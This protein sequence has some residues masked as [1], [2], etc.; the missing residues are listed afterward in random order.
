MI[1]ACVRTGTKYPFEYVVKLRNMVER[2]AGDLA[3]RF[4]CLT[5]QLE[6]CFGIEFI[7]ISSEGLPGWW[8][9]MTLLKWHWRRMQRVVY[10]DLDT[11]IVGDLAPLCRVQLQSGLGIC[12]NF[13][14]LAG[15]VNWPCKYNSSVMV[16]DAIFGEGLWREFNESRQMMESI[17]RYGDQM[18]IERLYPNADLLQSLLPPGYFL[19]YRNLSESIPPEAAIINFGGRSRP[20]NCNLAWV[21]KAWA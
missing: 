13:A 10:L 1:I 21:Q 20:H 18:A 5:D 3:Y 4:V 15:A 19:N 11:V 9:K 8:G 17:G 12:D 14:R 2:H 16:I 7:D 6:R